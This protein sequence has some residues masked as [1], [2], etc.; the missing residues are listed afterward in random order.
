MHTRRAREAPVHRRWACDTGAGDRGTGAHPLWRAV[1]G[2][3]ALNVLLGVHGVH[4]Q[5]GGAL[6]LREEGGVRRR[7]VLG[8]AGDV[9]P[10][11]SLLILLDALRV[12]HGHAARKGARGRGAA[13]HANRGGVSLL[14]W[15]EHG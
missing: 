6:L 3:D 11:G 7:V 12:V 2:L 13:L 10:R 14:R 4:E 15:C 8:A 9:L 5:V 1:H